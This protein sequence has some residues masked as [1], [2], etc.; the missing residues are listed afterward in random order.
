MD[1]EHWRILEQAE[2]EKLV[3]RVFLE[4][5]KPAV[6]GTVQAIAPNSHFRICDIENSSKDYHGLQVEKVEIVSAAELF[7]IAYDS[8]LTLKVFK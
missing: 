1:K 5:V 8:N 7:K 2:K 3:V 4:N 6:V